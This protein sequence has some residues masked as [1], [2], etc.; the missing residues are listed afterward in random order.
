MKRLIF[1]ALVLAAFPARADKYE[2][3]ARDIIVLRERTTA[4]IDAATT[5]QEAVSCAGKATR[6]CL[7]EIGDWPH[8]EPR[9]CLPRRSV[10]EAIYQSEVMLQLH[11]ADSVDRQGFEMDTVMISGTMRSAMAA[12][13]SWQEYAESVCQVEGLAVAELS[14]ADRQARPRSYCRERMYAERIFYL[15]SERNWLN[16]RRKPK[17]G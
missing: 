17:G 12:E 6:E 7:G 4:C 13:L 2:E 3:W 8:P 5:H 1:L 14:H 9:D 16:F 15:R 10:W 11:A